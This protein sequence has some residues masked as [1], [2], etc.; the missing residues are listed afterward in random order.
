MKFKLWHKIVMGLGISV[1]LAAEV[2]STKITTSVD[3]TRLSVTNIPAYYDEFVDENGNVIDVAITKKEFIE[4]TTEDFQPTL[5][6]AT[7]HHSV[8]TT[9]F[10]TGTT[11]IKDGE[12]YISDDK[13]IVKLKGKRAALIDS[14][15]IQNDK[16]APEA[17]DA[18]NALP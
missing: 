1:A 11:T 4:R 16:L 5:P 3:L 10:N 8:E 7:W 6:N 9:L 2:I 14:S 17:V 12:V 15:F 13:A 18:I